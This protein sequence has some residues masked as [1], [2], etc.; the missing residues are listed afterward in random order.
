MDLDR[1]SR[2]VPSPA[3]PLVRELVPVG[4]QLHLLIAHMEQ[5]SAEG[6]SAA[7]APPIPDVLAALLDGVLAPLARRH[8]DDV[9]AAT[10]VLR[11]VG[12]AIEREILLVVPDRD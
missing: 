4:G 6:H 1:S 2:A 3:A 8:P 12:V 9:L 7:D 5:W 10:R 11:E